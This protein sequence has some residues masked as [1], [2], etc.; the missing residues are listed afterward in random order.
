MAG[1]KVRRNLTLS[2]VLMCNYKLLQIL[3]NIVI[4][5]EN[6]SDDHNLEETFLSR[7][8]DRIRG[9]QQKP[10]RITGYVENVIPH[11]TTQQF[12]HFRMKPD[13]FEILEN[14][15]GRLL[16]DMEKFGHPMTPVHIQLLLTIWLLS[17]P[18]SFRYMIF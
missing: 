12:H 4:E 5:V 17:T 8:I 13:V 7:N 18:D 9:K 10:A 3:R 6:E 11:Y 15:L 2:I 1:H 16:F 14:R